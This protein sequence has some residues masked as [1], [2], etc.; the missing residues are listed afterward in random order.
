VPSTNSIDQ[1]GLIL[2]DHGVVDLDDVGVIEPPADRVLGLEDLAQRR[3]MAAHCPSPKR[4]SLMATWRSEVRISGQIDD[5]RRT[6]AEGANDSYLPIFSNMPVPS[7]ID[8][9]AGIEMLAAEAPRHE[10]L[11]VELCIAVHR[12]LKR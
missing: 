10:K 8:G 7:P 2:F 3:D 11:C 6:L 5:R 9:P 4:I 1:I 12:R